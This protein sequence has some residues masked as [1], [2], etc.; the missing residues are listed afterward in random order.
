M[1]N[2]V[3]PDE[4]SSYIWYRY[5]HKSRHS[6]LPVVTTSLLKT[7]SQVLLIG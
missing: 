2:A 5:T 3:T 4:V 1:A 7:S 6:N